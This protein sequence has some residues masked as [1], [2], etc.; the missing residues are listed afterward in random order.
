[1]VAPETKHSSNPLKRFGTVLNRRRQS[2]HPYGRASSPERK[3][4]SNLAS[5]FGA[6]GKNK[7]KDRD[8]PGSSY[9]GPGSPARP[10]VTPRASDA[11]GSPR[12][13][14]KLSTDRP[15]GTSLEPHEEASASTPAP[16]NGTVT[17]PI[18]ELNEV[19]SP[20][21]PADKMPEVGTSSFG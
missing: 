10:S 21:P 17:E 4:S 6:F 20:P 2:M 5:G 18:P 14:R 16:A 3:S 12:Q 8:A 1:M 11:S 9:D 13:T 19:L 15:N 7:S